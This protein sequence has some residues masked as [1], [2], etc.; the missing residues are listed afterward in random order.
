MGYELPAA[1]GA[2][3]ASKRPVICV[4]GDGG[5]QLNV[6][7]L[8]VIAGRKLPIKIFVV[9]NG[10]YSSIRN[11]QRNHFNGRYIASN[12]ETGL[13]IPDMKALAAAYGV[14]S[15]RIEEESEL[16]EGV[17]EAL[18]ADG[19]FLCDVVIDP[20]CTVAPRSTTKV[21][22]DG[23][24]VSTPLED[25]FPFLPEEELKKEMEGFV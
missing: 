14:N 7:E 17:K 3:I 1:I 19:P 20:M 11:M 6:Q 12:E 9:N 21:L 5:M 25:L 8:A 15:S 2:C 23:S 13:Y 16:Y 18:E 10:G 22:A 4:A 24:I